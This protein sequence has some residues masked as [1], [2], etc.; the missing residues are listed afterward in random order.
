MRAGGFSLIEMLVVLVILGLVLA[1]VTR[2]G[3]SRSARVELRGTAAQLTET[4]RLAQARA[5]TGNRVSVVALD[6]A[7]HGVRID[8]DAPRPLPPRLAAVIRAPGGLRGG[9]EIRFGPDGGSSGGQIELADGPLRMRIDVD[10]LTGRI[11]VA[12][13]P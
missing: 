12:R 9:G 3:Q 2:N 8:G 7:Q 13:V 5:I 10:W 4:L 1:L 6:A 11:A